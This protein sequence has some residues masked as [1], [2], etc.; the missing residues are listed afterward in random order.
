M[1]TRDKKVL[2]LLQ[3]TYGGSIKQISNALALKYKLRN[4]AGL[5]ALINDVNGLIR[6]P[7]RLLQMNKLCVK[8][9]LGLKYSNKLS[10]NNGWLSFIDSDGSI[11]YN[12]SSGQ[13]FI[14]IFQKK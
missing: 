12:E 8:F 13:V 10:F 9:N 3:H 7:T 11:Y 6:N 4:K 1:N 2:Y 5:I 14:S